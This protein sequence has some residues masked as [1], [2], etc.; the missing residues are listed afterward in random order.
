M[1][2]IEVKNN[3]VVLK[4]LD[5]T[6]E[7]IVLNNLVTT[8]KITFKEST[9]LEIYFDTDTETK[10]NFDYKILEN[11]VVNIYETRKGVKTKVQY[12]YNLKTNSKLY[13]Y[14]LNKS[15]NMREV[16]VI[17][18][19][20]EN[21][22]IEFNLRTLS[23]NMEKYDIY[24]S[25][26]NKNTSSVVNNVGIAL[27][28]G[29]TFNVTGEVEKGNSGSYLDQN[30]QIVTFNR[31]KCQINPNL[32]VE[33]FDVEANHNAIIGSFDDDMIFYLMS[34]GIN[35]S[36]AIRL[37]S[38]GLVINNLKENYDKNKIL[39]FINEYWG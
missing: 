1:N 3:N 5:D 33:E 15:D 23:S 27:K 29:I 26:N 2:R 20:G 10:L 12:N 35:E 37:L 21:S 4:E 28:G 19:N 17:N 30:N 14:R 34:R 31:E 18:L 36:D 16:D 11:K 38:E 9:D 7:F 25:H 6:I 39:E 24:I 13:L 22:N 8:F 32:L